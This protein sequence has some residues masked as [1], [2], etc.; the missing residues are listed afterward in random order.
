MKNHIRLF[1]SA[2]CAAILS[3]ILTS[4]LTGGGDE[5]A[6][7]GGGSDQ[8]NRISGVISGRDGI[9][10]ASARVRLYSGDYSSGYDIG[11]SASASQLDT[12]AFTDSHG[13]YTLF[14]RKGKHFLEATSVDSALISIRTVPAPE[15]GTGTLADIP[16][17]EGASLQGILVSTAKVAG[18]HLA[19]THFHSIPDSAGHFRFGL[20]PPGAYRVVAQMGPDHLGQ[21]VSVETVNLEAGEKRNLD[22]VFAEPDVVPLFD[23]DTESPTSKLSGLSFPTPPVGSRI[24]AWAPRPL[25]IESTGTY[26]KRSLHTTVTTA[27]QTGFALGNGYYD[28]SKM[29]AFVFWAKGNGKLMV[30][31]HSE[32]VAF[33]DPTLRAPITLSNV[34]QQFRITPADIAV[35]DNAQTAGKGYTWEAGKSSVSK[36]SFYPANGDVDFWID[37]VRIEGLTYPELGS[38]RD[39][40][41][42]AFP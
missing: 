5:T 11:L 39:A 13:K 10:T 12:Q 29:S 17:S 33:A 19:G 3:V 16:L 31:F 36:I 7:Q 30:M 37:D 34:W 42:D 26:R 15:S 2:L 14:S 20:L 24:G 1:L 6:N 40:G 27:V 9:P 18:L 35:P 41:P 21:L 22:S 38:A 8:P 32:I 28:L 4:C 25:N 23:F